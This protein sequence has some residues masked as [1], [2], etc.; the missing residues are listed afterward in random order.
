MCSM[1][2]AG[3]AYG[4]FRTAIKTGSYVL[5]C[6]VASEL[7]RVGLSEA[8]QLTM[9]AAKKDPERYE[10]MARRWLVRF[11]TEKRPTLGLIRY[12]A[13]DL[14]QLGLQGPAGFVDNEAEARLR[15]VAEKL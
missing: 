3:T 9:L 1:G 6:Q 15:Q 7:P 14:D 8:L 13:S 5:A 12:V 2:N 11:I 10:R 4:N